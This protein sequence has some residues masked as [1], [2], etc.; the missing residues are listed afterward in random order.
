MLQFCQMVSVYLCKILRN[1][2][3]LQVFKLNH[4]FFLDSG[5]MRKSLFGL[6]LLSE[7]MM[8]CRC[9][10]R[11]DLFTLEVS[12]SYCF[13]STSNHKKVYQN[14]SFVMIKPVLCVNYT[15]HNCILYTRNQFLFF[16]NKETEY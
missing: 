4:I 13:V 2:L 9:F 1:G 14:L 10:G 11:L 3:K 16:L 12:D 7:I 15:I 6:A 5:P 8:I